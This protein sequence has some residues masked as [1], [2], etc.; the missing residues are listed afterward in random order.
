MKKISLIA[1]LLLAVLLFQECTKDTVSETATSTEQLLAVINDSTW[2]GDTIKASV[3]YS[4]ATSSKLFTCQGIGDNKEINFSVLQANVPSTP[5]FPLQTYNVNST[6]NVAMSYF[7]SEKNSIG[8]YVFY[9]QGNVQAGS[10]TITITA[11]DS[12]KKLIT[13]TFSFTTLRDNS[14]G[15]TTINGIQAGGFND[16]PYTF[17]S[18]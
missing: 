17:I 1:M 15:T 13:G 4:A 5:G 6:T 18:N 3:T 7:T 14:D 12:V 2:V 9:Q 11:V 8:T 16:L 10:G